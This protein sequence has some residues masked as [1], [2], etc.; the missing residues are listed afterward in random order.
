MSHYS[1]RGNRLAAKALLDGIRA[2]DPK[3]PR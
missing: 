1:R 3:C 2:L